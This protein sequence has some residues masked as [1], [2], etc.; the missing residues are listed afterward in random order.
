MANTKRD[1]LLAFGQ[2]IRGLRE[3][4]GLSRAKL[5][6]KANISEATLK[7]IEAGTHAT[8]AQTAIAILSVPGMSPDPERLA[9]LLRGSEP[10][11][12][13]QIDTR[14]ALVSV[15]AESVGRVVTLRFFVIPGTLDLDELVKIKTELLTK[16][17]KSTPK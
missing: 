9:G 4:A 2:V 16:L 6:L 7:N 8:S 5:A 10:I 11:T 13:M 15:D 3:A 12:S 1:S 17:G 14:E